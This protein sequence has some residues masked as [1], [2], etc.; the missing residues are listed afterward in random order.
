MRKKRPFQRG[1]HSLT[2]AVPA[3]ATCSVQGSVHCSDYEDVNVNIFV[4]LNSPRTSTTKSTVQNSGSKDGDGSSDFEDKTPHK[5]K[6][7]SIR[8]AEERTCRGSNS[9]P[10]PP[11][12]PSPPVRRCKRSDGKNWRCKEAAVDGYYH[13]VKHDKRNLT[14]KA[15]EEERLHDPDTGKVPREYRNE[16]AA[17]AVGILNLK[18]ETWEDEYKGGREISIEALPV[19]SYYQ[20]SKRRRGSNL[21]DKTFYDDDARGNYSVPLSPPRRSCRRPKS[22]E[23][24]KAVTSRTGSL[25]GNASEADEE[26]QDLNEQAHH[27]QSS[28]TH[29][30]PLRPRHKQLK[31]ATPSRSAIPDESDSEDEQQLATQTACGQDPVRN[32][33]PH[34]RLRKRILKSGSTHAGYHERSRQ[35]QEHDHKSSPSHSARTQRAWYPELTSEEIERACPSCRKLCNCKKCLR[36]EGPQDKYHIADVKKVDLSFYILCGAFRGVERQH[37]TER[38]YCEL[39]QKADLETDGRI[40]PEDAEMV[41]QMRATESGYGFQTE[42]NVPGFIPKILN[43][44][45]LIANKD[46]SIKCP[47]AD[48]KCVGGLLGLKTIFG[49]HWIHDLMEEIYNL[50]EVDERFSTLETALQEET[51]SCKE[52]QKS[53]NIKKYRPC[54]DDTGSVLLAARRPRSL[55]NLIY[56]PTIKYTRTED[57]NHFRKHWSIGE[58]AIIRDVLAK[59][60]GLSWEPLVMW[61]ALRDK[62]VKDY[63]DAN[64]VKVLNCS[65]W[66]EGRISIRQFFTGYEFGI[67]EKDG[68][69][70]LLKLS[71]WPPTNEFNQ[72]LRRHG[73]EFIAALP[74]ED[75][76]HPT[77][78]YLNLAT[79]LPSNTVKPDL[80]PKTYIAYGSRTELTMG[81]SVTKLHCD[82]SDAVNIIT[83][84]ADYTDRAHQKETRFQDCVNGEQRQTCG[85]AVWDIFRRED[86]PKLEAYIREHWREFRNHENM[87]QDMDHPIHDKTFYLDSSHKLRLKEEYQVEPWTFQQF[88]GEAVLI[89]AGCPHQV[90]NLKSCLKVALD[91]V[92]PEN[93]DQCIRLTEEF[94]MLPK[95][96]PAKEDKLEVKKM[97]LYAAKR[98]CT[99]IKRLMPR[100]KPEGR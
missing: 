18:D 3:P 49:D 82:I 77:K 54:Q 96:H 66:T 26:F 40:R 93:I 95:H 94:R 24:L 46:G 4:E 42:V 55:D 31:Q 62:K 15:V 68:R 32:Y 87:A 16:K 97:L 70:K 89:P 5:E 27:E 80:G 30:Y 41:A 17:G 85:G 23:N 47:Q 20:Q 6:V 35:E 56:C 34:A 25:L 28:K 13:C 63:D 65:D 73:T 8:G 76:C 92:S 39:R 86:V 29:A 51:C 38:I 67:P 22:N 33:R 21:S 50:P 69:P 57:L 14:K 43:P 99:D 59:T 53:I 12:P 52:M 48:G 36:S 83:H 60:T 11:S 88:Y 44:Q 9:P 79:K 10:P 64:Y 75:Y 78:G 74:F 90:R 84:I 98:A 72:R 71:D 19:T 45:R 91:F 7:N 81:N 2:L 58:P 37:V 1:N 100:I 61:R